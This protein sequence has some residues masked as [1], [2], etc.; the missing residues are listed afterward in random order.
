M[1]FKDLH[2]STSSKY[3]LAIDDEKLIKNK[4]KG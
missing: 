3:Q 1:F 2:E 4:L